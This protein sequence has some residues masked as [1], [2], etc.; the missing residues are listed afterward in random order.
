MNENI[1]IDEVTVIDEV[2]IKLDCISAI[3]KNLTLSKDKVNNA[4]EKAKKAKNKKVGIFSGKKDAIESLQD[5]VLVQAEATENLFANQEEMH[6]QIKKISEI[7]KGLFVI[8]V[9]NAAHTRAIVQEIKN[10]TKGN[11]TDEARNQL[12][13]VIQDLERQADICDRIDRIKDKVDDLYSRIKNIYQNELL[14][15]VSINDIQTTIQVLEN[16]ILSIEERAESTKDEFAQDI[17]KIK[18][19][20]NHIGTPTVKYKNMATLSIVIAILS[21][22]AMICSLIF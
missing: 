4:L 19:V 10:K 9:S 20:M 12:L 18:D 6:K 7:T 8:G 15:D 11:L 22:V 2:S 3:D 5:A 1:I 16:R 14:R 13:G 17:Q 21:F